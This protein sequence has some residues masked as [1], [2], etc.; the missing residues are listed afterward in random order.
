MKTAILIPC[1]NEEITIGKVMEDF[2]RELPEADIYVYDNNSKDK[3]AQIAEKEGAIVRKEYFQG[4]GMVVRSMF[5]EID[6]DIYVL[7]DGDDTYPAKFVHELIKPILEKKAD[8]VVGDRLSNGTYK[9]ENKRKFHNFGNILVKNLINNLFGAS[10]NDIMSGY[11]AFNKKFVKNYPVLCSGFELETAMT[12]HALDKK[13]KVAEVPIV[14]KDRPAGSSSKVNTV[15]DGIKII[16]TIFKIFKDYRSFEFLGIISLI[17]FIV[18]I[19]IGV[20]VIIEYIKFNYITKVPSAI[21][22]SGIMILSFLLFVSGLILDTTSRHYREI[23]ELIIYNYY[24]K[25]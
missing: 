11:R 24:R 10:L 19:F 18:G 7:V 15:G 3:T 14:Y 2:R 5:R 4:K 17:F 1:F 12:L 9:K 8:M 16:N 6:A 13:F 20:P 25:L 21:L 23:Y 22:A